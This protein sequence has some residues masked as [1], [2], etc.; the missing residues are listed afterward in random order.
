VQ[1][2]KELIKR[3]SLKAMCVKGERAYKLL[4]RFRY[5]GQDYKGIYRSLSQGTGLACIESL[6][7]NS[8]SVRMNYFIRLVDIEI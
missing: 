7:K 6:H 4:R 5:K 2:T 8:S 3:L 1:G